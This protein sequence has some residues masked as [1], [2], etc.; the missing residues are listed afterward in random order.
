MDF[1][2]A[3]KAEDRSKLWEAR[4]N[5]YFAG[6]QLRPGCR[7]IS[8]DVCVPISRLAE[9]VSETM[10]DVAGYLCPVPLAGH[11]GDGNFHLMFLVDPANRRAGTLEVIQQAVGR[12]AL[13][14]E[15]PAPENGIG[16]GKQAGCGKN[17]ARP[18][19]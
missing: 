5:F 1:Q 14:M 3:T 4:H 18:S 13:A 8:T 17:W 19:T 10:K 7:A 16:L 2:W 15:A 11:V 12:R 9:C 6:L